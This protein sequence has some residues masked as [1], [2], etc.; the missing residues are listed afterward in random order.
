MHEPSVAALLDWWDREQRDLPWRASRDRYEILVAEVMSQ[1]T[2]VERVIG[3][4]QEWVERWPTPEALAAA[5]LADVLR[6]WQGLGY[7]RRARALHDCARIV[8]EQGWP[9]DL[10]DL[11]GVGPYTASAVRCFADEEPVLPLDV[12]L[13]RVLARRWP[14]G[15]DP[16]GD[17]WRLGQALME[18]GQRVCR[19][20][21]PRCDVCP[22]RDGCEPAA[23]GLAS[24]PAP[25]ARRQPGYAGSLRQR[26]GVL[27]KRALAG[28]RV[29]LADDPEAGTTLVKDGLLMLSHAELLA[30]TTN[31]T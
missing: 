11:P 29:P 9:D 5:D 8:T 24:D 15:I 27:L 1:Q 12:N 6:A 19:A 21:T 3:R 22:V 13:R 25:K 18:F 2:Q 14:H 16:S 17:P 28:E 4:W 10:T 31:R 30:P 7:P 20:R 23:S 26:R